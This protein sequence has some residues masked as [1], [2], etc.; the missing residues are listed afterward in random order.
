MGLFGD[1]FKDAFANDKSLSRDQ[2]D[3][4]IDYDEGGN[5]FSMELPEDRKNSVKELTD[6]QKRF[7]EAQQKQKQVQGQQRMVKG[8][9]V[10]PNILAGTKWSVELFLA[11]VPDRD[12][13]N[14]LYGSRINISSRDRSLELGSTIPEKPSITLS[15]LFE[16]DG[17]CSVESNDFTTGNSGEWKLSEDRKFIRFSLDTY[18]YQRTVTTKGTITKVAWSKE[19]DTTTQTS[20]V[21]SIPEGIVYADISI[22]YGKPGELVMGNSSPARRTNDGVLRIE[23]SSGMLGVTSK[24]VNCGKFNACMLLE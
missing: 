23:Q 10:D 12:P 15:V 11:G 4:M 6:V 7:L 5:G 18:G 2:G 3:Q 16:E 21:Y 14:N 13:S 22:G 1:I 9:P 17:I 19:D 20:S 24:M 8:A